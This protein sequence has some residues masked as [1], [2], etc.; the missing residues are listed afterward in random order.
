MIYFRDGPI[1]L[2]GR[3]ASFNLILFAASSIL[4]AYVWFGFQTDAV[5]LSSPM[6]PA[7]FKSIS[8]PI[9]DDQL[10]ETSSILFASAL[11]R[12]CI[13]FPIALSPEELVT[14]VIQP[15]TNIPSQG[16]CAGPAHNNASA[17]SETQEGLRGQRNLRKPA[18]SVQ[19]RPASNVVEGAEDAPKVDPTASIGK[20]AA[21]KGR[22]KGSRKSS[23]AQ[24]RN[25]Q[26]MYIYIYI[27]I[28]YYMFRFLPRCF[29][30]C[31]HVST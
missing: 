20:E 13:C 19:K 16:G 11:V 4:R 5:Q 21:G 12:P 23:L 31:A 10:V 14:P 29:K 24:F 3:C 8:Q 26:C 30:A 22:G 18:A 27:Y 2:N 9:I 28:L 25:L 1:F 17:S 6:Q 7:P 15:E